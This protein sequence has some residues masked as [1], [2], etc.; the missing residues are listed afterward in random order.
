ML[1]GKIGITK[2]HV[3]EYTMVTYDKKYQFCVSEW[4]AFNIVWLKLWGIFRKPIHRLVNYF[5]SLVEDFILGLDITFKKTKASSHQT[6]G[7][8]IVYLEVTSPMFDDASS[9][10][11]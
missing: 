11:Q 1:E 10:N 4:K 8:P 2:F 6:L 5:R 7:S 9:F 3:E